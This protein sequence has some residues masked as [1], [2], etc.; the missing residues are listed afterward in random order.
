MCQW[1]AKGNPWA[2]VRNGHIPVIPDLQSRSFKLH[3]SLIRAQPDVQPETFFLPRQP[4]WSY[5][6]KYVPVAAEINNNN[7]KVQ[8]TSHHNGDHAQH[9]YDRTHCSRSAFTHLVLWPNSVYDS[10]W[11]HFTTSQ[12][13]LKCD[14]CMGIFVDLQL[15]DYNFK[16]I[17]LCP[18]FGRL[19]KTWRSGIG[20]F[21]STRNGFLLCPH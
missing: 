12:R 17:L 20:P 19:G 6:S 4:F 10:S 1:G 8:V 18:R 9:V 21:D 11:H 5:E 3:R 2:A 15:F 14:H 7:T 13:L 16:D